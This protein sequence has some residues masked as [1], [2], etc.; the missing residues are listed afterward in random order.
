MSILAKIGPDTPSRLEKAAERRYAE[1]EA[2]AETSFRLT[3]VY[4]LG[5][6]AEMILGT[7]YFRVKGYTTNDVIGTDDL[8]KALAAAKLRSRMLDKSHPIDGW[9]TLLIEEKS[10]LYPPAYEKRAERQIRDKAADVAENW[11]PKL[12][13]R[14]IDVTEEQVLVVKHAADWFLRNSQRLRG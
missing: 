6:V 8:R 13:Y 10:S 2:L 3:S 4:L 14:A 5:Y 12:R 9:A 11:G 1:A 7:T